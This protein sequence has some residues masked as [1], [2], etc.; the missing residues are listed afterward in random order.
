MRFSEPRDQDQKLVAEKQ[1]GGQD[2]NDFPRDT[3]SASEME[4]A[5]IAPKFT[6][7]IKQIV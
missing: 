4:G 1:E 2:T 3:D 5:E 7:A 6:A